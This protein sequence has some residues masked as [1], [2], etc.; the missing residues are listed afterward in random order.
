[1]GGM[2]MPVSK[3][4][5]STAPGTGSLGTGPAV[6]PPVQQPVQKTAQ[7]QQPMRPYQAP[8]V[9]MPGPA[10]FVNNAPMNPDLNELKDDYKA[11]IR[12]SQGRE[13]AEDPRLT[14]LYNQYQQRMSADTT[15]RAIGRASLAIADQASGASAT[16]AEGQVARG[17]AGSGVGA[18]MGQ[19]QKEAAQRRQ[20]GAAADISLA[21]EK[22]L[23][24][25]T[26]G[27]LG[28]ASAQGN[29]DLARAGQTNSL[30]QGAVGVIGAPAAQN[31]NE[32]QFGLNQYQTQANIDLQRQQMEE[33]RR[34]AEEESW[35]NAVQSLP[36]GDYAPPVLGGG[37][38]Y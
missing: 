31:L 17:V 23:D 22:D 35:R 29:L 10:P 2:M 3:R 7:Q 37:G 5:Y 38:H 19:R 6:A 32:R 9:T 36:S 4:A 28:I 34:R 25:L 16:G 21:R 30:Y 33:Q 27:G 1:M 12:Q 14:N 20:A 15:N 24:A 11:R 13:S 18:D 8:P 26:L